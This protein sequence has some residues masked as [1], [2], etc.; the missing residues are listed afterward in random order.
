MF[1]VAVR[2]NFVREREREREKRKDKWRDLVQSENVVPEVN[3]HQAY[4]KE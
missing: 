3:E 1:Y 2:S 4:C